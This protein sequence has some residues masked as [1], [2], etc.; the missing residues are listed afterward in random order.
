MP[1]PA[2][3]SS[4]P[5]AC[6]SYY[7]Q[8]AEIANN[9][10]GPC[11]LTDFPGGTWGGGGKN[12]EG[13][14]I[15]T[16]PEQRGDG[17]NPDASPDQSDGNWVHDNTFNTQ[18]NEC[19]DIKEDASGNLVEGNR[20][21]GQR[22]PES[23]G[24]DSR[25]DANIFRANTA[26]G[27]TCAGSRLGGDLANQG[28]GNVVYDNQLADNGQG[29]LKVQRSPQGA[30]C[31]NRGQTT[32][33]GTFGTLFQPG[34]A[35]D[36]VRLPTITGPELIGAPGS[37]A[38]TATPAV[39]E[40]VPPLPTT[41][42]TRTPRVPP[43]TT[44][45]PAAT[46]VPTTPTSE[47]P[48][49]WRLRADAPLVIAAPQ[50]RL[51]SGVFVV[52]NE[53]GRTYLTT[54]GRGKIE[55]DPKQG[56]SYDLQVESAGRYVV[57]VLGRGHG[58]DANSVFVRAADTGSVAAHFDDDGWRWERLSR[59]L[60]FAAG[61]IMLSLF[62]RERGTD[63]QAL[64]IT[65]DAAWAPPAPDSAIASATAAPSAPTAAATTA[66]TAATAATASATSA[67]SF[68]SGQLVTFRPAHIPL[69]APELV[70]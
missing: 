64:V 9:Q 27:N 67:P 3:P 46:A 39:D 43:T 31:G 54:S 24:F 48:S 44:I 42:P 6:T 55:Q 28:V 21:T 68:P 51:A 29:G 14:Y 17:K 41:P 38:P 34:A 40:T 60:A 36:P 49:P 23:A 18:G 32:A 65:R 8:G 30:I 62:P 66:T 50:G 1:N 58:D 69:D 16:A 12:G 7:V 26:A 37:I 19:V 56:A 2:T 33:S 15:G 53:G 70:R 25:G 11:G 13:V 5:T 10:I 52:R 4:S 35:C 45:P 57:W 61:Q 59:P 22:D 47:T 63:I 20:C